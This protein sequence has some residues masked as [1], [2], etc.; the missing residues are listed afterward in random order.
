[1]IDTEQIIEH[2]ARPIYME[3]CRGIDD[4]M[5]ECQ[6]KVEGCIYYYWDCIFTTKKFEKQVIDFFKDR[7]YEVSV[8]E[9]SL[10]VVN[11]GDAVY[12]LSTKEAKMYM[13]RKED[14][15]LLS[16]HGIYDI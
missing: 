8:D 5:K 1:M 13:V 2:P 11:V 4:L 16:E 14:K 7:K 9:T 10:E 15:H 3:V 6:Q 12:L